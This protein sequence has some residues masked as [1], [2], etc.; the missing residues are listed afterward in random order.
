MGKGLS[1][2]KAQGVEGSPLW[3][4]RDFAER[5]S[6]KNGNKVGQL[7]AEL[8]MPAAK[9]RGLASYYGDLVEPPRVEVCSGTSC[10]LCGGKQL[11]EAMDR[12]GAKYRS[13]YC[14]GYCDRSPVLLD[15]ERYPRF[16]GSAFSFASGGEGSGASVMPDTRCHSRTPI[17]T[18]RLINGGAA[19]LEE[20]RTQGAYEVL[21]KTLKGKP[22]EV[23]EAMDGSGESGRG[24]AGFP[25]GAKWRS[26]AETPADRRYVIANGDEGDPGSFI[27][28]VLMEEDPHGIL[29]GML[30]C[31]FAIGASEGVV[32][33]RSEYPQAMEVMRRAINEAHAAGLVG[34]DI[35]GSG[36]DFEVSV[37]PGMG[38]YVCGEE[39]ALINALEGERGE[40]KSRP[41]Y[42]TQVGLNGQPTVI[43]NVETL[44]NVAFI[45]ADGGKEYAELGTAGNS[46][47]KALSLNRGFA[48]PGIVEVECGVSLR[49]VIEDF[50]GGGRD[51]KPLAAVLLGGPMGSVLTPGE[52]D[53]PVSYAEM[54]ALGIALG[55]GGVV[56]VPEDAD[57]RA[58]LEH[59]IGF[60]IDESC[61]K[62][63]PCR[64]GSQC[65]AN[66]LRA[67]K[68]ESEV[69]RRLDELFTAMEQGSLCA[70]GRSMPGP[71]R[72]LIEKF[73]DRIFGEE[74]GPS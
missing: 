21:A 41:P 1:L 45:V 36:M 46:G 67:G 62:C 52:W 58:M 49:E 19:G 73:G 2:S 60:M 43:N 53:V 63:V 31:A 18:R 48:R 40:V 37:F 5:N 47:T 4:I 34:Q 32:F 29:E 15:E 35:L 9:V 65:A 61:G 22:E 33:I 59:W 69:R 10:L 6:L 70:F 8:D 71:M 26:C 16:R 44:V 7:A 24:G 74:G 20:A 30:L 25:T 28:R 11:S 57:F 68:G 27:D 66:A 23:L 51:G 56:A 38:S 72:E 42:P 3:R 54:R 39:T 64:L 17:V 50:A 13:V 12:R 14:L 55:H